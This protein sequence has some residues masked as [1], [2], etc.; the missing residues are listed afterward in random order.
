LYPDKKDESDV[1][2][3][4][5]LTNQKLFRDFIFGLLDI[6]TA[7]VKLAVDSYLTNYFIE[8][9]RSKRSDSLH[10]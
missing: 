3:N 4:V 2:V 9:R 1:W 8:L 6:G 7:F 5:I 10:H